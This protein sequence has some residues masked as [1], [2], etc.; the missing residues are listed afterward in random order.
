MIADRP[1]WYLKEAEGEPPEWVKGRILSWSQ[2]CV[3]KL[4]DYAY[5]E[6]IAIVED[7]ETSCVVVI[8]LENIRLSERKPQSIV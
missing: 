3:G 8:E 2:Y 1:C 6:P 5:N 7:V 4:G